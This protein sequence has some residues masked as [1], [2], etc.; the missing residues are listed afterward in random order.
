MR[1]PKSHGLIGMRERAL[2]LGGTL[3]VERGVNG[4]GTSVQAWVPLETQGAEP[5]GGASGGM[6]AVPAAEAPLALGGSGV[7]LMRAP[8]PAADGRT[9]F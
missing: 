7:L 1:R 3:T 4:V 6:E 5:V 9:R 2:L 8:R